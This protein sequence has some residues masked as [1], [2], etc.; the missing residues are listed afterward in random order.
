MA[1]F[2]TG[3]VRVA[4]A[5]AVLLP[6]YFALAAL[7]TRA[8]LWS[9]GFGFGTLTVQLGPPLILL[10]FVVSLIALGFALFVKPRN[11]VVLAAL[12]MVVPLAGLGGF[13]TL[14]SAASAVPP[15]HDIST[16]LSDP[17][18]FSDP[19]IEARAAI[20]GG[21]DLDLADARVP[22]RPMFAPHGG[23]RVIDL[24]RQAYP[25]IAP[26][27]VPLPSRQAYDLAVKSAEELGWEIVQADPEALR[28]EAVQKSFWYG[29]I[30]DIAVRVRPGATPE[31]SRI[32]LRSSSRFGVSDLGANAKRIR[33]FRDLAQQKLV[34][35]GAAE[36]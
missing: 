21:N 15:I 9:P 3:L 27:F 32:D 1:R 4:A 19:V 26:L 2:R 35:A 31:E 30:D 34:R 28:F 6:V 22:D 17:P 14:R 5:L 25:D 13:L 18:G 16:D 11:G 12:A 7:G 23:A 36:A 8:R 20:P 29:F 10:V 24:Q 33:A